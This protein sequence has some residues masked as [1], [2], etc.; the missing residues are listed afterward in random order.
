MNEY[1]T[2]TCASSY[3]YEDRRSVFIGE[4]APADTE[5][6]ALQ[7]LASVK[8]KY[9]DARHHVYA[10]VLREDNIR[11]Y[12]DDREPQGTAGLPVLEAITKRGYTDTVVVVTRYFG[13]TLLGTGG[14]VRAYTEAAAG[15]L[16]RALPATR[17]L[18][19]VVSFSLSYSDFQKFPA[20]GNACEFRTEETLY[21]DSVRVRGSLRTEKTE[22]LCK[23]MSEMTGG[24]CEICIEKEI[25]SF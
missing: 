18:Y 6:E 22:L 10:Y 5:A 19:A 1:T 7:F 15:A 14:L 11:R 16:A 9:P 8:K 3:T 23:K 20:I 25:F 13:G 12:S 21:T 4:A 17:A 2:V 24:K